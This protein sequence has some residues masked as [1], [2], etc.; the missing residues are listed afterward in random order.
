MD[1]PASSV[2]ETIGLRI[3]AWSPPGTV[4]GKAASLSCRAREKI[5]L[6]CVTIVWHN[7][8]IS[9]HL[10]LCEVSVRALIEAVHRVVHGR[11]LSGFTGAQV[12]QVAAG[13]LG[14]RPSHSDGMVGMRRVN[15]VLSSRCWVG[16]VLVIRKDVMYTAHASLCLLPFNK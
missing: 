14:K 10:G 4:L 1:L 9:S 6:R 16:I 3:R 11:S 7:T 13:G 12:R 8:N 5:V 15:G 2:K